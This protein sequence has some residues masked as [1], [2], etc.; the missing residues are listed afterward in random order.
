M[1]NGEV[2]LRLTHQQAVVLFEWLCRV[3]DA[4]SLHFEDS[5][6]QKV[7]WILEG[8][9]ESALAEPLQPNYAEI[10]EQCRR[11]VNDQQ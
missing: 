1:G 8:Q 4:E 6:E 9:L 3:D 11:I 2:T 7:L 10:V 5:S